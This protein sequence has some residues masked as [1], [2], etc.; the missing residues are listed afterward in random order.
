MNQLLSVFVFEEDIEKFVW[1]LSASL[2]AVFLTW[3][4]WNLL[5]SGCIAMEEVGLDGKVKTG[6]V[7]KDTQTLTR[8]HTSNRTVTDRDGFMFAQARRPNTSLKH[9][10]YV[11]LVTRSPTSKPSNIISSWIERLRRLR[12]KMNYAAHDASPG[13]M[14][15]RACLKNV[16]YHSFNHFLL[17]KHPA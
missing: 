8:A 17:L 14:K 6:N 11:Y 1:C 5:L 9:H 3:Y 13:R 7:H 4:Q 10:L 16:K 12:K 15:M 2:F